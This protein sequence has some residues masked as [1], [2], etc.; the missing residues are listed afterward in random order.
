[1]MFQGELGPK[2]DQE[3]PLWD[4][5]S[6]W[7]LEGKVESFYPLFGDELLGSFLACSYEA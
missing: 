4:P 6:K 7:G 2:K 5:L 1:M 3:F